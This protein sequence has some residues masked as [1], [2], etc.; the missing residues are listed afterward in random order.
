MTTLNNTRPLASA[1]EIAEHYGRTNKSGGNYQIKCPCHAPHEGQGYNL[2]VKDAPG[3]GLLVHCFSRGCSFNDILAAFRRDGLSVTREWTYPGGKVV[4]RTDGT[5][6]D[7]RKGRTFK[8]SDSQRTKG[9]PLL[10]RGDGPD[11][12]VVITEGESDADA[13]LAADMKDVA[14]ACFAGGW[15]NAGNADYSAIGG[16]NVAIWAD[17]DKE[18]RTAQEAAARAAANAGAATVELVQWVGPECE[19]QGAADCKPA[20]LEIFIEG[21]KSW[22]GPAVLDFDSRPAVNGAHE[23]IPGRREWE[24]RNLADAADLP[25]AVHLVNGLLIQGNITLWFAAVKTGKSRLLM[26]LLAAMSPG[27]P[28]FCGMDL[29]P[30]P[31]LLFT[32][33][34]PT[35]IGE[36]VRDFGIP[37]EACHYYNNAAALAMPAEDFAEEVYKAYRDNGGAFGL[38]AVDTLSA[39]V[40]CHDWNDYA[41][42]GAA[43]S[44]LRQ[45]ARSLPNVAMLL[46]HHQNKAGGGG[47]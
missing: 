25:A 36:R 47:G 26:G 31:T 29:A 8:H 42:V 41:A 43:M 38:I 14:A 15:G 35:A 40:S 24:W 39:F 7:Y 19:G 45:L 46:L 5:D 3:G 30:T 44:P 11:F 27:G 10:I 12:L 2:S 33:E 21:R 17:N 23:D 37:R 13:V 28:Q 20:L 22:E 16:R 18:G 1:S 34:P 9:V 4:R 32:E 6:P